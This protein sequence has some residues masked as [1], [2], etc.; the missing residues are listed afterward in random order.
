[1]CVYFGCFGFTLIQYIPDVLDIVKPLNESRPRI[2]LHQAKYFA[3]Q[4]KYFYIVIMHEIIAILISGT[5][6]V[7][8]ETFLL[9]N[10][11]HAFGMFKIARY[12]VSEKQFLFKIFLL[13]LFICV[14]ETKNSMVVFFI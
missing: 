12:I 7:A 4:E 1:M 8:A 6:G 14:L 2:L 3:N 10:S 5:T 13:F 11:L 9:V